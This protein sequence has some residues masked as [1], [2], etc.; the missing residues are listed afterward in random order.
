MIL[1]TGTTFTILDCNLISLQTWNSTYWE[2]L[3]GTKYLIL[4][5][6]V[7]GILAVISG[8]ISGP[9]HGE[10]SGAV[11]HGVAPVVAVVEAE[12]VAVLGVEQ[13]G[14]AV[15]RRRGRGVELELR[16]LVIDREHLGL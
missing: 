11:L 10:W 7:I 5:L 14:A 15:I 1:V 2:S 4:L 12:V 6:C 3:E 13:R 9:G 16:L 8:A